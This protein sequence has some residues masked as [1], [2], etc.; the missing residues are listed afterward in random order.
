METQLTLNFKSGGHYYFAIGSK[1]DFVAYNVDSYKL[2]NDIFIP[3]HDLKLM[4]INKESKVINRL[5]SETWSSSAQW[6]FVLQDE[7]IYLFNVYSD[8]CYLCKKHTHNFFKHFMNNVEKE[9]YASKQKK[10]KKTP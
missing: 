8:L 1:N 6:F 9:H 2:S 4:K 3:E 5:R 10:N 7:G